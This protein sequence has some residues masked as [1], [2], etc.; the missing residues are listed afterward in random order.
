MKSQLKNIKGFIFDYGGTIDTNGTHWAN[1]IWKYYVKNNIAINYNDF[2]EAYV[3]AERALAKFP[4]IRP[5]Y[6][7]HDLLKTKIRLQIEFLASKGLLSCLEFDVESMVNPLAD[8]CYNHVISNLV[9]TKLVLEELKQNY[10]LVLVSNFYGNVET[11]LQDFKIR[12]LFKTIIES[13]VVGVRKPNPEIFNLGVKALNL[14]PENC[15]VVGDSFTK[16]II[17]SHSIG[18][19]TIWLK[20]E[21]WTKEE[22]DETIP[23]CIISNISE[24]LN[25]NCK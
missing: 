15:I 10:P 9:T 12:N 1:V 7:F 17:P 24:L 14:S 20:G 25:I 16:D 4:F 23:D 8:D 21:G 13:A 6:N 11:V 5:N 3:F 19:R 22:N 2:R 18:C